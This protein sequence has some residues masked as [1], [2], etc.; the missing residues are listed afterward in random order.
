MKFDE[1]VDHYCDLLER[2]WLGLGM[3]WTVVI[4]DDEPTGLHEVATSLS[5]GAPPEIWEDTPR[6]VADRI[7]GINDFIFMES[8][9]RINLIEPGTIHE[10]FHEF[11]RWMS[12]GRRVWSVSWHIKGGERLVCAENGEI[13][14]GLGEHFDV[15]RPF[16]T[17]V[18]M[19]RRELEMMRR[20]TLLERKAAALAIM[21]L[22][23]R[24][25]LDE[26]WLDSPQQVIAVDQ[27]IPAGATPPSAFASV[28]PEL[29]ARLRGATP[30]ARRGF[31]IRLA[32]RLADRYDLHIPE[33]ATVLDHVRAGRHPTPA[34]W[35]DLATETMYLAQD[36]WYAD[37]AHATPEW[38]RWQAAIAIRHAL[39]SLDGG[40]ENIESLLS[41]RNALHDEWENLRAEIFALPSADP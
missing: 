12:A 33:I 4:A 18:A 7:N 9:S 15:N 10:N 23:G 29:A 22:H 14:F 30:A 35:R 2:T 21:G 1:V 27:P 19:A 31:L 26:A 41:A 11:L 40:G 5:G 20:H 39:R 8:G 37:P 16:G 17:D 25:L 36:P 32:E 3:A 28:E 34:E 13:L 6:M 38:R 24:C